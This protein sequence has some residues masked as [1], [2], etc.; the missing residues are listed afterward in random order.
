VVRSDGSIGQ[1]VGGVDAK[2]TLLTLEGRP[3]D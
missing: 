1:Y 3:A 2:R